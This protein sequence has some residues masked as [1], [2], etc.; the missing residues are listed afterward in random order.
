VERYG[1]SEI[2]ITQSTKAATTMK[3]KGPDTIYNFLP[4]V[5][6]SLDPNWVD[7]GAHMWCLGVRERIRRS[8]A[9]ALASWPEK[10]DKSYV[11]PPAPPF[12]TMGPPHC[13][14]FI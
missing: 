6:S 3:H 7:S 1:S 2:I 4:S 13:L 5:L 11:C 10:K 9:A 14:I 12:K 8:V